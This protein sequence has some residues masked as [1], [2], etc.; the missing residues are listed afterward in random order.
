MHNIKKGNI[1]KSHKSHNTHNTHN[2]H[3]NTP[4]SDDVAGKSSKMFE[5]NVQNN[6]YNK[7]DLAIN[8]KN[9]IIFID[10]DDTLFPTS[11]IMEKN[12]DLINPLSRLKYSDFFKRLDDELSEALKTMI[13]LG[14]V[15]IIT[16]ALTEWVQ[17]S[18]S[19]LPKTKK[20]MKHISVV[21]ARQRYQNK[22]DMTEWKK[23]T[24]LEEL[25]MRSKNKYYANILSLGDADYEYNA[26]L[27][28]Y[29]KVTLAPHKYLKSIR[30]IKRADYKILLEQLSLIKNHITDVI[31][32]KRHVD[33]MFSIN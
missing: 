16:N 24:F 7:K 32:L 15:V 23:H 8:N 25:E 9:T 5:C 30:F 27:N 21:S 2:S 26:L 3:N 28:L 14:E 19:I 20:V 29:D 4:K 1:H 12:V 17:L 33:L 6:I 18:L 10:W 11:W 22:A 31:N 13:S